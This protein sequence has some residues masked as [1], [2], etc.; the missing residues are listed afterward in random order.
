MDSGRVHRAY[1]EVVASRRF[2][3]RFGP[4]VALLVVV[5]FLV[6]CADE[7]SDGPGGDCGVTIGFQGAVYREGFYDSVSRDV[8]LKADVGHRLS[9][10]YVRD[11]D[12]TALE[13]VHV[14]S[15]TGID[16]SVAIFVVPSDRGY[17]GVYVNRDIP[18]SS[19]PTPQLTDDAVQGDTA[20]P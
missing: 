17:G 6:G 14:R 20:S 5:A 2:G 13:D 3:P 10:G 7:S 1:D 12:G 11:C 15:L 8:S 9:D 4:G 18:K 16:P 19:W